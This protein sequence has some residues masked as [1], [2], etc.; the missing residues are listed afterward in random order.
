MGKLGFLGRLFSELFQF[1][2]KEKIYW[3]LPLVIVLLLVALFIVTSQVVAPFI[4]T[5]F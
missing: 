5:L 1:A 3:L 4:Y 2:R